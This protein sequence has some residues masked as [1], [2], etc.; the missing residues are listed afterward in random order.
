MTFYSQTMSL[1]S[2]EMLTQCG[3]EKGKK[4]SPRFHPKYRKIKQKSLKL[5]EMSKLNAPCYLL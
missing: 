4:G 2:L 3:L 1:R 5:I